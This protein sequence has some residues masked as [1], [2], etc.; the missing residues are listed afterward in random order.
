M[1]VTSAQVINFF[2]AVWVGGWLPLVTTHITYIYLVFLGRDRE[3][4]CLILIMI[5]IDV[6]DILEIGEHFSIWLMRNAR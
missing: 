1:C 4:K 6:R 3:R 5:E 2:F